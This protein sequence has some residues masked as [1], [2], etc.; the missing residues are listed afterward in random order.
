MLALRATCRA[1]DTIAVESPFYFNF[2][3][4]IA[5]LGLKALE[6]PSTPREGI[7]IEA[8]RYAIEHNRVSACLVIPSFGNPLGSLMPDD[9]KRELVELLAR[10]EIPL[11]EDDI[12]GDL[13]DR[14]TPYRAAKA[15][16]R[17]GHVIYCHSLNKLV[18][19]GLRL[20]WMLAGRWQARVEMLKYT[21]S[22]YGEELPQIVV[23]ELLAGAGYTRHLARLRQALRRQ[24]QQMAEAVAAHFPEGT[25]LSLPEGGLLLWVQMPESVSG[26]AVFEAALRQGIKLAPGSLFSNG[27]RYRN[28]LRLSCGQPHDEAVRQA[29]RQ[30]GTMVSAQALNPA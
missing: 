6:I 29:L 27:P 1:G 23:A 15:Y 3:Q 20:G 26:D 16:D 17:S 4:L 18:A 11:I 7:S 13:G 21:Q 5:D 14:D 22:R 10:H 19:P 28:C 30:V 24:R 25:R 2:L 12:Y 8:L 9:R